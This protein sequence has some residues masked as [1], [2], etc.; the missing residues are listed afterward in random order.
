MIMCL[1]KAGKVKILANRKKGNV[2]QY[3]V[4]YVDHHGSG[5]NGF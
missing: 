4:E 3:F 5:A 2:G 1:E